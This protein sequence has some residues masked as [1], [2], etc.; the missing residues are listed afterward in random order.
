[1]LQIGSGGT[2]VDGI[3]FVNSTAGA[4]GALKP[5]EKPELMDIVRCRPIGP[6]RQLP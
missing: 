5:L 6:Q 4:G 3:G 1:V 2:I